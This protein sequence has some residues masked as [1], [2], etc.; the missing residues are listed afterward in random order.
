MTPNETRDAIWNKAKKIKGKD[1][2]EYRQ[3][4]YGN[5]MH[6]LSY[7]K[8]TSRGWEIDHIKPKNKGG[9]DAPVNLQALNTGIN[10]SKGDSLKKKSRHSKSNK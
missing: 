7:G 10:R 8:D 6:K 1:P 3:D 9:S 4:P 5:T 2:D